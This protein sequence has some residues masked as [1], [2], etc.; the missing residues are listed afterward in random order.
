MLLVSAVVSA[1][2]S[3]AFCSSDAEA[4]SSRRFEDIAGISFT[5]NSTVADITYNP[6]TPTT[7]WASPIGNGIELGFIAGNFSGNGADDIASICIDSAGRAQTQTTSSPGTASGSL[8]TAALNNSGALVYYFMR[9]DYNGDGAADIAAFYTADEP[10]NPDKV[11]AKITFGPLGATQTTTPSASP[12]STDDW[13]LGT[14]RQSAFVAGD[15]IGHD[16]RDDLAIIEKNNS[17]SYIARFIQAPSGNTV[18]GVSWNLGAGTPRAFRAGDFNGDGITDLAGIFVANSGDYSARFINGATGLLS[19]TTWNLTSQQ[20]SQFL[21]GDFDNDSRTDIAGIYNAA[22]QNHSA[23]HFAPAAGRAPVT[24]NLSNANI[25]TFVAGEFNNLLAPT[26]F[27]ASDGLPSFVRVQFDSVPGV[28]GYDVLRAGP[29]A[30]SFAVIASNIQSLSYDDSTAVPGVIYTY[31]VR[32]RLNNGVSDDS[33]TDT[34]YRYNSD[35]SLPAPTGVQATDGSSTSGVMVTWNAVGGATS[36]QIFRSETAGEVGELIGTSA[37]PNFSDTTAIE[38]VQYLYYVKAVRGA[39][40]SAASATDSGSRGRNGGCEI[41]PPA[42][43]NL[44]AS[45]GTSPDFVEI[46]WTRTPRADSYQLFRSQFQNDHGMQIGGTITT[47]SFRD[48]AAVPG[49][50]YYYAVRALNQFGAGE[51]SNSDIGFRAQAPGEDPDCDGDGV[52]DEQEQLDGTGVCDPGSFQLHL[53]SPAF[54]AYNTFLRQQGYLELIAGGSRAINGTVTVYAIDGRVINTRPFAIPALQQM[55]IDINAMVGQ[56]DTYGVVRVDFNGREPGATL[57]GRMSNYRSDND[58]S[59]SFAFARELRNST[60][61]VTFAT[62]NA[63]DPQGSGFLVPNWAEIINIDS[64]ERSFIHNLYLQDGRLVQSTTFALPPLA[65]RDIGAG[66][67]YGEGV[68]VS[69]FIPVDGA[70]KYL[71]SVTRYSSNAPRGQEAQSY[72]FAFQLEAKA[73]NGDKQY[74][75]ITNRSGSCWLQTNWVEVMNVREKDVTATLIFRD[76]VGAEVARQTITYAP[77]AQFHFNAS[78]LL[79]K[80]KRGSVEISASDP[81]SLITQSSVYFHDTC[82][83]NLLQ[84]A[85]ASPGRIAGQD[86]QAGSFNTNINMKNELNVIATEQSST[87]ATIELRSQG[88]LLS[89]VQN[90]L[91]GFNASAFDLNNASVFNTTQNQYGTITLRTPTIRRSVA[92]NLRIRESSPGKIDFVM[93]TPLQ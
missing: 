17:G 26:N 22:A 70:T 47:T 91:G 2:G 30:S 37:T 92:E 79:D 12:R 3:G 43:T 57:M 38:C 50:R 27:S 88:Q 29:G 75:P 41:P 89:T 16:R 78:A 51:Y 69:E 60:R 82:G 8:W 77:R 20:F 87:T 6:G 65:K 5:P 67:E 36:Y 31:K 42:P 58:G 68:Y 39:E 63:F 54:T 23:V 4:Q 48:T 33:N 71:A 19:S 76:D 24:W 10:V 34:G 53:K 73:G 52:S 81:A 46:T 28:D 72:N 84:S 14:A 11:L 45:D 44:Q 18:A 56:A 9:G 66:H 55:D 93:Y 90:L 83:S 64:I 35:G 62:G 80:G 15:F 7:P 32:A 40:V 25:R 13:N 74:V 49:V 85:Y 1:V 61:G 59:Y 21:V 86:V